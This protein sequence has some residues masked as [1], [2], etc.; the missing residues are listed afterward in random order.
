[1]FIKIISAI[2]L[3]AT[4]EA[5]RSGRGG[6]RTSATGSAALWRLA[7]AQARAKEGGKLK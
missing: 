1:M 3:N 6:R 2:P 4:S 5:A 7:L